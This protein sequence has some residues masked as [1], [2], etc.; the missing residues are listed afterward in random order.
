[1][2]AFLCMIIFP[3]YPIATCGAHFWLA[4][5]SWLNIVYKSIQMYLKQ[6]QRFGQEKTEQE[7]FIAYHAKAAKATIWDNWETVLN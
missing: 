4:D 6:T 1:M 2:A 3:A 7:L 5:L